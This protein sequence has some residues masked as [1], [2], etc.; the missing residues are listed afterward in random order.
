MDN[1]LFAYRAGGGEVSPVRL[2][3]SLY[4]VLGGGQVL[5]RRGQK[6]AHGGLLG[7]HGV[8]LLQPLHGCG[9]HLR[10]AL[11]QHLEKQRTRLPFAPVTLPPISLLQIVNYL[12]S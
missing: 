1:E 3:T 10:P 12:F 7:R 4:R 6:K 11:Y 2:M 9:A 8:A 5:L